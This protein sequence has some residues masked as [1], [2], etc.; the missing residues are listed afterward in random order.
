MRSR[1]NVI[2][3]S[4]LFLSLLLSACN[5]ADPNTPP[6]TTGDNGEEKIVLQFPHWFFSHGDTFQNWIMDAVKEYETQNPNIKI[7]GY[8]YAYDE[9]WSKIDTAI[10]TGNPPDIMAFWSTNLGKYIDAEAIIPLDEYLD[11]DEIKASFTPLQKGAIASSAKDGKTYLVAMNTGFYL[12]LY[13]PSVFE[14][15]GVS[16]FAKNLDEFVEMTKQLS[17]DGTYGY[18]AMIQPGNWTEG[19]FDLSI[20]TIGL[21]GQSGVDG[22]PTLDSPE[23]IQ[24]VTYLKKLYDAGV[25]PKE[26]DKGTYRKM[27]ATGNVATIIDGPWMYPL[28]ENWN[29][30]VKGDFEAVNLPFPTQNVAAFFEGLS[31]S[32]KSKHPEEAA[33]FI[34]YLTSTEQQKKLIEV[35]GMMPGRLSVL[36][37]QAFVDSLL[38]KWPWFQQFIDHAPNA[39][40]LVPEGMDTSL[41]PE[42]SK[43]WYTQL[44]KVLYGN[45]DPA[46]AMK[47][48]QAE[49]LK[50]FNR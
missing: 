21:G 10:A 43:I 42:M 12:P 14:K 35:S 19:M 13:R 25:M 31:V 3:A 41:V 36:E 1:L 27:F 40:P 33:K 24:A 17:K 38:E 20:W 16:S 23:V 8:A 49:A 28:A 30:E 7:E 26:T 6:D 39:K 34:N 15:H 32:S 44:E 2:V 22:M 45:A 5:N 48:A 50:L 29:P 4:V 18:A 11:I 37:D 46:A 9:Y 47:A